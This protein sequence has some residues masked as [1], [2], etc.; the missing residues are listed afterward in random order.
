[1]LWPELIV[2]GGGLSDQ[3]NQFGH[4]LQAPC[5]IVPAG[6]RQHAGVIG[7]ALAAAEGLAP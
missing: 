1:L 5:T 6:C 4:L 7:A 2:M 3:W